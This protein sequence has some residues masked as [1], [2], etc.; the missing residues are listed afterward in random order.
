MI[1]IEMYERYANIL[2]HES[3][4]WCMHLMHESIRKLN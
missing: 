4:T 3:I 1:E 2:I